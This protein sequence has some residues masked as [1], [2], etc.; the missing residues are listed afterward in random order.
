M[1]AEVR[2]LELAKMLGI[3]P[4]RACLSFA[5]LQK[6]ETADPS[7]FRLLTPQA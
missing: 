6:G 4:Q 7:Q 1:P 5:A 2:L 3:N